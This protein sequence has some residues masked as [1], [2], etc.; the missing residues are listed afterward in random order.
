MDGSPDTIVPDP[1]DPQ[2]LNRYSYV[3]NNP[4][5]YT[6]PT[7][8]FSEDKI[9]QFLQANYGDLWQD[10]W[11]A[12]R[13]DDV[14][15]NMLLNAEY[16]DVLWAPT[17]DLGAGI[18]SQSGASFTLLGEHELYE[19]QGVGPYFLNDNPGTS[20][21]GHPFND[22]GVINQ[23]WEQPQYEYLPGKAPRYTGYNRVV[24]YRWTREWSVDPSAGSGM[25]YI[26]GASAQLWRFLAKRYAAALLCPPCTTFLTELT[27]A[28]AVNNM[29]LLEYSMQVRR[30]PAMGPHDRLK[31]WYDLLYPE[32][33][34]P[35]A[36]A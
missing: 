2:A 22:S 27:A 29:F 33:I 15:W 4:L 3:L 10:Y 20:Y 14:F 6:D 35:A 23:R 7:G 5:R 8:M 11:N 36:P 32:L 34:A 9:E 28:M 1:G 18:F 24:Q 21:T 13:S 25:P 17:S 16:G 19:Y 30:R 12:W 26:V 31:T